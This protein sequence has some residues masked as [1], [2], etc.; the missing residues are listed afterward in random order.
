LVKYLPFSVYQTI[1]EIK[2][3]LNVITVRAE[4]QLLHTNQQHIFMRMK[5]MLKVD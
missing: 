2:N 5:N 1:F 4:K 3:E